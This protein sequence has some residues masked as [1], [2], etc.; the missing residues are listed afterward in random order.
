MCG[1]FGPLRVPPMERLRLIVARKLV[2][3]VVRPKGKN[4]TLGGAPGACSERLLKAMA[5]PCLDL[6][7]SFGS[8]CRKLSQTV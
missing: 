4:W 8:T 2:L 7:G 5:G 1:G 6:S 3:P